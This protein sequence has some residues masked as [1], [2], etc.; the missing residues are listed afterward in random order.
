MHHYFFTNTTFL[1]SL[2][3]NNFKHK[4]SCSFSYA[5]TID[6]FIFKSRK[7]FLG[8]LPAPPP[9]NFIY[10]LPLKT[11]I[12]IIKLNLVHLI[13]LTLVSQIANTYSFRFH[14]RLGFVYWGFL[15]TVHHFHLLHRKQ[16]LIFFLKL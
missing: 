15:F 14:K 1:G 13:T 12:L 10:R 2:C 5:K 16:S 4:Y 6:S 8:F 9:I 11:L 7:L 3:I